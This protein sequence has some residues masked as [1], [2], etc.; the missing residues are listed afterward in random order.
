MNYTEIIITY[1][2][3][4]STFNQIAF[5]INGI[6]DNVEPFELKYHCEYLN[7]DITTFKQI[8][9][10]FFKNCKHNK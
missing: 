6:Y 3:D 7:L 4:S 9:Y 2:K 10:E 1:Y 8:Q 5:L